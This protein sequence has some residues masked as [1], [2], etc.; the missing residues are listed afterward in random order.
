LEGTPGVASPISLT[1]QPLSGI[2]GQLNDTN[3]QVGTL[4]FINVHCNSAQ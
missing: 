1:A 4:I 2:I 3:I